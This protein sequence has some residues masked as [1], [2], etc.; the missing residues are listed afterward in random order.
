MFCF[1]YNI[2]WNKVQNILLRLKESLNKALYVPFNNIL[3]QILLQIDQGIVSFINSSLSF[4]FFQNKVECCFME[5]STCSFWTLPAT[6]LHLLFAPKYTTGD[7]TKKRKH[8]KN[9]EL[10]RKYN[11]S[12]KLFIFPSMTFLIW[13]NEPIFMRRGWIWICVCL[14]SGHLMGRHLTVCKMYWCNDSEM[15][16]YR[17]YSHTYP[18][19]YDNNSNCLFWYQM[20]KSLLRFADPVCSTQTLPL[21]CEWMWIL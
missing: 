6:I 9:F 7:R 20:N 1:L 14:L 11:T 12:V 18:G 15:D 4:K 5:R 10:K 8:L 17:T 13:T 21:S 19:F 3:T 2:L 16:L